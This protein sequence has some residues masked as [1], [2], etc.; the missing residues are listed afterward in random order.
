M[1]GW[2]R[3]CRREHRLPLWRDHFERPVCAD[4]LRLVIVEGTSTRY[5]AATVGISHPRAVRL[6]TAACRYVLRALR[7]E[8]A[9]QLSITKHSGECPDPAM[10]AVCSEDWSPSQEAK[11]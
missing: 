7:E 6:L 1:T 10:C 3:K 5:A 8:E 2:E 11:A 9:R 4:L